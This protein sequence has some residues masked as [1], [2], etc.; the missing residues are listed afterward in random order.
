MFDITAETEL[1]ERILE[2]QEFQIGSQHVSIGKGHSEKIVGV[3]V[4]QILDFIDRQ[5]W[6]K[7]R[8]QLRTMAFLHDLGKAITRRGE[9][10]VIGTFGHSVYSEE[11]A[12]RFIHEEDILYCIR[13]HDKYVHFF[14]AGQRGKFNREKFLSIYSPA[15][16]NLLTRFNYADSNNR[17]RSSVVWFEDR[18][19]ENNL[20]TLPVYREEPSVLC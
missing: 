10:G 11:I 12:R 7:F 5:P 16:L 15:N 4:K 8:R 1:E 2:S 3:H 17:D 20:I 13:V 19:V 6:A 14:R 18:C 9:Q